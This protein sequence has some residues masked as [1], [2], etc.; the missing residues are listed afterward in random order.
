MNLAGEVKSRV[1]YIRPG[2]RVRLKSLQRDKEAWIEL[3]PT[4]RK[5][6]AWFEV[7]AD[8]K[9]FRDDFSSI[10]LRM[11]KDLVNGATIK[12]LRLEGWDY[13]GGK[14]V[15]A[16]VCENFLLPENRDILRSDP[17]AWSDEWKRQLGNAVKRR[18]PSDV[19]AEMLV[20]LELKK[21]GLEPEWAGPRK[22]SHD[23]ICPKL[24]V[25]VK[26]S[27]VRG[28]KQIRIS[29]QYQAQQGSGLP[30]Y[31]AF[32]GF[33]K[34][35]RG[36]HTINTVLKDLLR[37]GFPLSAIEDGLD[38]CGYAAGKPERTR[39]KFNRLEQDTQFYAVDKNFPRI[40]PESFSQG[41]IP[42][43]VTKI[44]YTVDLSANVLTRLNGTKLLKAHGKSSQK[45][46]R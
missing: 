16:A 17:A 7:P 1:A 30:L 28:A 44:E 11:G 4:G 42:Q 34:S 14:N 5:I 41:S 2:K 26:S 33:E 32:V 39:E 15:F 12:T 37:A 6:S 25:E 38:L 18:S 45:R 19:I 22:G 31:I 40:T 27:T 23:I 46:R 9:I 43:G 24:E 8:A 13:D 21:L 3:D 29:S 20:L 35:P 36:R 10:H